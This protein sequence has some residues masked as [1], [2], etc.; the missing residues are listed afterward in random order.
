MFDAAIAAAAADTPHQQE[1]V[2][3]TPGL[4]LH[5]DG[6]YL[7]YYASGNDDTDA[8]QARIN[9][10]NIIDTFRARVGADEVIVHNTAP[11]SHKG[12]RYLIATV[13]PYQGQRSGGRKPKN[14]GYLQDLLI[15]YEGPAF[16]S[17]TWAT[18]E[19]DD[20]M[21]AC[22][23]FA[24]G[25]APGYGAIATADKDMRML[26]GVHINWKTLQTTRVLPGDYS[27]IGEDG[28]QYGLKWFWLQMLQGDTAD[29]CPGLEY[30]FINIIP[31]GPERM[32]KVGEKTAEK[33]LAGIGSSNEAGEL[34]LDLYVRAYRGRGAEFG[35]DRF[36]EQAALMWMRTDNNAQVAD[37]AH[38]KG[39][40][41]INAWFPQKLW[42]AVE[43]LEQRV[44]SARIEINQFGNQVSP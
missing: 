7:A 19:A 32:T 2:P 34:V 8:G 21:G 17:K 39:H 18:R 1:M 25:R 6:D 37:F 44:K 33:I 13:K 27:V 22:S 30:A 9:A 26:P 35:Y 5:V 11:G 24:L 16:R 3:L 14:H 43:R 20:G 38:H 4:Q 12:E 42:D 40:S 23:H 41:R 29:N 28:K 15:G 31:S 36:C 10:M